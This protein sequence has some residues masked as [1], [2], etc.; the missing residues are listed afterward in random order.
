M[1]V[2]ERGKIATPHPAVPLVPPEPSV[3]RNHAAGGG[4]QW[5]EGGQKLLVHYLSTVD[6]PMV[7][8]RDIH[9]VD[10]D[11][12]FGMPDHKRNMGKTGQ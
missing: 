2:L 7:V 9:V 1:I 10:I 11:A 3:K 12:V 4:D 8:W 5:L 6:V